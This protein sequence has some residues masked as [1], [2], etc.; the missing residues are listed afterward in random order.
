MGPY[1]ELLGRA[2]TLSSLFQAGYGGLSEGVFGIVENGFWYRT[3][4]VSGYMSND[5]S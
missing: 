4:S 3:V 1:S 2:S 5:E